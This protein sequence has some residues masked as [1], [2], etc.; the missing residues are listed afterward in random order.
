MFRE[1]T[2]FI[3]G[4][5]A[6]AEYGLPTGS[7]L[8]TEISLIL[9]AIAEPD[10][11]ILNGPVYRAIQQAHLG[12]DGI[13]R[14]A[15]AELRSYV[16]AAQRI[17]NALPQVGSIDAFIEQQD[18]DLI[19]LLGKIAIARAILS[20]ETNSKLYI[21]PS[22]IYNKLDFPLA[23]KFWLGKFFE[24]LTANRKKSDV[25]NVF[26]GIAIINFNYDRCVEQYLYHSLRNVYDLD[27]A[28]AENIMDGLE[29]YHPYGKV[30][31]LEWQVKE[32]GSVT[33]RFGDDSERHSYLDLSKKILTYSERIEDTQT[34]ARIHQL[35]MKAQHM[36]F[37]GFAFHQQNMELLSVEKEWDHRVTFFTT[38]RGV[39]ENDLVVVN[40]D[41][42]RLCRSRYNPLTVHTAPDLTCDRLFDEYWRSL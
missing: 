30:G 39:S 28:E 23:A 7:E 14:L 3:L 27:E 17:R 2:V 40:G 19:T 4:A 37:L 6:S 31:N 21:N 10:R 32:S 13:V 20:A 38:S 8:K 42:N 25:E 33:A 22:N 29:I 41:L 15:D 35:M 34:M 11:A 12:D 5:G 16:T 26:D 9:R 24:K 1:K 18:D 36:V